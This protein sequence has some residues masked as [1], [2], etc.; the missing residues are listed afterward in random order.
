MINKEL[1]P[2]ST[3]YPREYSFKLSSGKYIDFKALTFRELDSLF[4]K[5]HGRPNS[6]RVATTKLSLLIP[7]TFYLLN[8]DELTNLHNIIMYVSSLTTDEYNLIDD[9]LSI[10]G[11]KQ[12]EDST[13]KSCELC[14][15]SKLDKL[16]NCPLLDTSEH[17]KDVFYLVNNRKLTV[18]PMDNI[19]NN[20][21]VSDAIQAYIMYKDKLLPTVGGLTDQTTYF[22]RVAPLAYNKLHKPSFEDS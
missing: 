12:F 9:G 15:K 4:I 2:K 21:L 8:S 22:Y 6:L 10:I 17:S 7:E 20:I 3:I 16:R 14:K 13:F 18:C 11:E 1:Y 5:L 19:N